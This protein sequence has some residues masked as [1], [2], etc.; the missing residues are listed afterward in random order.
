VGGHLLIKDG[1]FVRTSLLRRYA[2]EAGWA[3][4]LNRYYRL[5]TSM[6]DWLKALLEASKP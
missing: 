5:G 1:R 4:T 2:P 6:A 3:L